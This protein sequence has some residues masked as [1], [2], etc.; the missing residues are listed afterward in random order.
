[1]AREV[2]PV[3]ARLV[4]VAL[5]VPGR[6]E[7]DQIAVALI[8]FGQ[9]S[10]VRVTLLLLGRVLADVDLAADQRLDAGL[11]GVLVELD[12]ARKRA[13]VGE[14]D[15]RHLELGGTRREVRDPAG[16]VEDRVLGVDMEV[17]E[18]GGQGC[19]ILAS[20]ADVTGRPVR[21]IRYV[22]EMVNRPHPLAWFVAGILTI[23]LVAAL[24]V[25]AEEPSWA[26]RS[27]WVYRAE[28]GAAIVGLLYLPLVAVSLAWRGETFRKVQAPGGAGVET[29]ATEIGSAVDEFTEYRERANRR[30]A[31]LE[32]AVGKLSQRV[33]QLETR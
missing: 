6:G 17:D 5:E 31:E 1:V 16:P 21:R 15:G 28:V 10:Q 19:A 11:P 29:P 12:G 26:L 7:L 22:V 33:D 30:F 3:D 4:V 27:E 13:V 8:R 18:L 9:E 24:T 32:S 25:D 20:P 14:R 23:G 2:A